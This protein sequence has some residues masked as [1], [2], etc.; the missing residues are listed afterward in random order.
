MVFGLFCEHI[1]I[2]AGNWRVRGLDVGQHGLLF[3]DLVHELSGLIVYTQ[4][5]TTYST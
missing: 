3:A 1:C 4:D 2:W 5:T